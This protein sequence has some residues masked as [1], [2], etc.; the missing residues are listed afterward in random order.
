[1]NRA[2]R[3]LKVVRHETVDYLPSH[4]VFADRSRLT[5]I[6]EALRLEPGTL[7]EYL[8][9]H[10]EMAYA[11]FDIPLHFRNDV[12]LMEKLRQEDFVKIDS[13]AKV[14]YDAWGMGIAMFTDGF[15]PVH[16]PLQGR[17]PGAA[18]A[19][20]PDRLRGL[21]FSDPEAAVAAYTAPDPDHPGAYDDIRDAVKRNAG[22]EHL[23]VSAGYWGIF[24]RAYGLRSFEEFMTDLAGDPAAAGALLEK[25]TDFKVEDAKR[26]VAAGVSMGHHGDDLATQLAPLF[27]PAMF[28]EL[29]LPHLRRLFAV[30]K[31]AGLPMAM[32]S[33]GNIGAFLPDL[34]D[35]GL[36]LLEPVQPCMDLAFLKRE[37]GR[38][39]AFWGGIDTQRLLPFGTPD[40]V[41]RETSRVIRTLGQGGGYIIGPSQEIMR[42]VPLENIVAM[43]ETVRAE[44]VNL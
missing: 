43:L 39:L 44:R 13:R 4:I 2:E 8:D 21:P 36:D 32:H 16:F 40:E 38:D 37:Y 6:E 35:I 23:V 42:D 27:S 11:R 31:E 14:V 3:V 30:Y 41:R 22:G 19:F 24:E 29:I 33:C 10:L 26:K 5:G 25:V 9:N 12:P 7:D 20:M 15:T 17:D 28:R 1:M 34:L 18:A